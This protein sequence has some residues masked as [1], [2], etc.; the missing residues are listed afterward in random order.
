MLVAYFKVLS[1]YQNDNRNNRCLKEGIYSRME[2]LC[3]LNFA[4]QIEWFGLSVY[5]IYRY[6]V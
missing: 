6:K 3:Q 4:L 2:F 1:N 5:H